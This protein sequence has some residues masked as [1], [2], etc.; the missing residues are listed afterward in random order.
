MRQPTSSTAAFLVASGVAGLVA[1][2]AARAEIHPIRWDADERFVHQGSVAAGR[3]TELCGTLPAGQNVRWR[4]EATAA[5]DFNLHY[6]VG[7]TV[8][9]PSKLA[10]VQRADGVLATK[11]AQDYC[12][13][14]T[15]TSAG[16]ATLSVTL[17]R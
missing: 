7:K 3:F 12:W 15:N 6:H 5:L 2:G 9:Y 16:P 1:S 13:M 8:V 10:A 11:I 4:F 17:Q 14:W